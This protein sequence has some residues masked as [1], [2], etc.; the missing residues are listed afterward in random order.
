M[1]NMHKALIHS[2]PLCA[3]IYLT[4]LWL[5]A[6]E[7]N[8]EEISDSVAPENHATDETPDEKDSQVSE[9]DN[10]IKIDISVS[11]VSSSV[12]VNM[13]TEE[14]KL[15]TED[16]KTYLT[17]KC[18]YPVISIEGNGTAAENINAD[19][20]SNIDS[21]YVEKDY[22][23][24]LKSDAAHWNG[25][26][27]YNRTLFYSVK[28][29]DDKVISFTVYEG[30]YTFG[31]H[32]QSF[33]I[34]VNYNTETGNQI[35]FENLSDDPDAFHAATLAYNI[36]LAATDAYEHRMFPQNSM[37]DALESVLYEND[38]WY[39]STYGLSFMSNPYMLGSYVAGTIEFIIPYSA[40]AEMGLK[41]M[42]TYTD[43]LIVK[44]PDIGSE[45]ESI[46][47]NNDGITDAVV[48]YYEFVNID[49]ENDTYTYRPHFTVNGTDFALD[50]S[51]DVIEK[52]GNI[53]AIYLYDLDINDNYVELVT[54]SW[55]LGADGYCEYSNFFRY[56]ENGSLVY[57]GRVKGDITDPTVS[58]T[59]SDLQ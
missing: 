8:T 47:L 25:G 41:D 48:S 17:L 18:T 40:L 42:Y 23:E 26:T 16:G 19:I 34:G 14:K 27:N 50:G 44:L 45:E 32:T 49:T 31:L 59:V 37:T 3:A 46:D 5:C 10:N 39:L 20:R 11:A 13:E 12:T 35:T 57:L 15:T 22:Y 58:V 24:D 28:R 30:E 2:W 1:G 9:S 38:V 7:A 36:E 52:L 54:S 55:E 29:A 4:A 56:T 6:C 21:F 33:E 53:E 51:D 43:R